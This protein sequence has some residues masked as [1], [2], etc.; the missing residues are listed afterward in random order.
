MKKAY[1]FIIPILCCF[2]IG[3]IAGQIQESSILN[4]HRLDLTD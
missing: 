3:F 1:K 4:F 2:L